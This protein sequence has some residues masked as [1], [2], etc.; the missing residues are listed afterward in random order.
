M[1]GKGTPVGFSLRKS[2]PTCKGPANGSRG[3]LPYEMRPVSLLPCSSL[4]VYMM[5]VVS[6]SDTV[7][8]CAA[9]LLL[10]APVWFGAEWSGCLWLKG[11]VY[12]RDT[13]WHQTEPSHGAVPTVS[14]CM[15]IVFNLSDAVAVKSVSHVVVTPTITSHC[16]FIIVILLLLCIIM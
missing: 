16:Y 13:Q 6:F 4:L 2:G 5:L 10:Q 11:M 15:S 8:S 1:F 12:G 3:P 14:L 7:I 9:L